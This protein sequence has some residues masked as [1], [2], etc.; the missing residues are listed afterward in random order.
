MSRAY[1]VRQVIGV[2]EGVVETSLWPLNG[3]AK[4]GQTGNLDVGRT[5]R[6]RIIRNYAADAQVRNLGLVNRND[7]EGPPPVERE[8]SFIHQAGAEH[9]GEAD[10]DICKSEIAA[11]AESWYCAAAEGEGVC[12]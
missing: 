11:G 1:A 3:I 2:L 8:T 10:D 6:I 5:F 4:L 7:G 9:G 12:E